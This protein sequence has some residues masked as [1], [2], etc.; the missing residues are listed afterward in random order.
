M[1]IVCGPE[2]A[3]RYSVGIVGIVGIVV[4]GLEW[5][6]WSRVG[7]VVYGLE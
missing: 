3:L 6:L 5:V 1:G 7:I 4:Y 2:W